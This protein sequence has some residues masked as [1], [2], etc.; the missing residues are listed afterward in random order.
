MTLAVACLRYQSSTIPI[1]YIVLYTLYVACLMTFV[2][3]TLV[4][5][6]MVFTLGK[7]SHDQ[8]AI[9]CKIISSQCR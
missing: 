7:S 3:S 5:P 4:H 1:L 9:S 8:N 2:V 6:S